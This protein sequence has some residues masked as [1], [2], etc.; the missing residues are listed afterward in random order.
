MKSNPRSARSAFTLIELLT[1]I[2]IIFILAAL[3]VVALPYLMERQDRAKAKLQIAQLSKALE[4]YKSDMG[5]YP[6]TTDTLD[7]SG[8][9]SEAL[10]V[11]LFYEGYDYGRQVTPPAD[12]TK[13]GGTAKAT[14]IY[15]PGLDP[16]SSKQGWVS[17]VTG[18]SPVPPAS[19][20]VVDPWGNEYRYRSAKSATGTEN[21]GTINPTF[22]LWS[23]GKDGLTNAGS[24]GPSIQD[25]KNRDDIRNFE[26]PRP[27]A[28]LANAGI[29]IKTNAR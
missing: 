8:Q 16:V 18:A 7:G 25:P 17:L 20:K 11:S 1:V 29:L 26:S 2:T 23:A 21:A 9:S 4:E 12:W 22:D 6:M 15:L 10:Y 27:E 19:T 13:A 28:V 5:E 14:R 24:T 3:V